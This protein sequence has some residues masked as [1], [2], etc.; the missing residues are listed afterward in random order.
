MTWL[1]LPILLW[2][3]ADAARLTGG[4]PIADLPAIHRVPAAQLATVC[5]PCV[6]AYRRPVILVRDDIDLGTTAGRAVLVHELVHH[7]QAMTGRTG[8]HCAAR[9]AAEVEALQA[10]AA[11]AIEQ[12]S[13]THQMHIPTPC[14]AARP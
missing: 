14:E 6:A 1:D 12:G 11:W 5:G 7:H 4:E 2:L 8:T 13:G 3:A 10:S 9:R